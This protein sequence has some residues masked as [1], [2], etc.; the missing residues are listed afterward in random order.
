MGAI[1]SAGINFAYQFVERRKLEAAQI[2]FGMRMTSEY[3]WQREGFCRFMSE[4]TDFAR[5]LEL[6]ISKLEKCVMPRI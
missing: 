2:I 6:G 1:K 5:E 4:E 3:E